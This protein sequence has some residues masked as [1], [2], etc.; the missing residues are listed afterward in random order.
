M[1]RGERAVCSLRGPAWR[2]GEVGA[3]GQRAAAALVAEEGELRKVNEVG[4]QKVT[5]LVFSFFLSRGEAST[6]SEQMRARKNY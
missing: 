1:G 5:L 3:E 2:R 6:E 4:E